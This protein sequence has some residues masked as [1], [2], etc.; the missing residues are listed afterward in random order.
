[1]TDAAAAPI[2][3][4]RLVLVVGPS[5][6]GKDTAIGLAR[7]ALRDN[8]TIVFPRRV[9]TRPPSADEDHD[10]LSPG[11]FERAAHDGAFALSWEAHGLH[12]GVPAAIDA[13][14]RA[15]RTVVCNVSRAIITAARQRYRDVL[16]VLVTAP[17][18]VLA[19][20]I[21]ARSRNEDV[22]ERLAR[23][24]AFEKLA[25]DRVVEN[26]GTPAQAAAAL[27]DAISSPRGV[28]V[29]V[30]CDATHEFSKPSRDAIRLLAGLGIADDA[31]M[32]VTVK[33]RSRVA[34]DPTQPNLRQVHLIHAELFEELRQAGFA[35]GPGEMGENVTTRGIDLLSL[36]TG[37]RL[38][39]GGAALVE[40]TGLRNPCVQ[41]DRF[42]PGLMA[43]VLGRD[44]DGNVVRKTGIMT[45]VLEGGEVRPGDPVGVELPTRPHRPLKPV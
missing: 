19:A 41:L 8:A 1:M 3:P 24:D 27:V 38:R 36:P 21:S 2:G 17:A 42:R 6:A 10:T 25:A 13:D 5:G 29:A 9:V 20:R 16:V 33:H 12:Y 39:L 11:A 18:E 35:V 32:G 15:G 30:S 37:T 45:I 4:G 43:A 14:I 28:V 26:I 23:A 40:V 7:T 34:R 22:A 44:P 31:H